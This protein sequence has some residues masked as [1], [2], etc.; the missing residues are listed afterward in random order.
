MKMKY[1]FMMLASALLL[2]NCSQDEEATQAIQ[3]KTNK[4]IATIEGSSRSA[5]TDSGIFSW[6]E[7]DAISVWN[8]TGF[9][10]FTFS[11]GDVFTATEQ[12]TPSGVAIHPANAL[13]TYDNQT[14][15]V[16]LAT[17]YAYGS[18]NAPLLAQVNG[19]NLSF[20]HLGGLMRFVV[21]DVPETA[22]SFK[23]TANSRITGNFA[24]TEN[25]E[26][27]SIIS[28]DNESGNTVTIEFESGDITNPMLFYVP[29]P[30]GVYGGYTIEIDGKTHTTAETVENTINRG[31]LLLMPT[32]TYTDGGL[33]K[34]DDN[35]IV[36]NGGEEA[37]LDVQD[38]ELLTVSVAQGATATLNLVAPENTTET[39]G[40]TDGSEND[41]TSSQ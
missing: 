24:V 19:A 28:T 30:V 4:L 5:V 41:A 27:E 21:K 38:G 10:K 20:K 22:T 11:S 8:G 23:F 39:L 34:G 18:T 7:G 2:S 25:S 16:E 37:E 13:H 40:I 26:N 12:I 1:F 31:S 36:F 32:F 14:A 15:G 35:L 17:E 29:L 33:L 3:G 6:T 9:T